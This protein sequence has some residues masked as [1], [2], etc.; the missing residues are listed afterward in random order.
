MGSFLVVLC[1]LSLRVEVERR[2]PFPFKSYCLEV[3]DQAALATI[4]Y[5]RRTRA[6]LASASEHLQ[7][8]LL[9][10]LGVVDFVDKLCVATI[11]ESTPR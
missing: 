5:C 2:T 9:A 10:P 3:S 6:A 4:M 11:V 7:L 1:L 8:I